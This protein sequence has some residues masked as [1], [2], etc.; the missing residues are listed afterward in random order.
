MTG[1]RKIRRDQSIPGKGKEG[2]VRVNPS[3]SFRLEKAAGLEISYDLKKESL[4]EG[5]GPTDWDFVAKEEK[6]VVPQVGADA[7]WGIRLLG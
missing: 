4:V 6:N 1:A 7:R 2:T 3:G 5:A